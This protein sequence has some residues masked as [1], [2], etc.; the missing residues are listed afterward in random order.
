MNEFGD[1]FLTRWLNDELSA[2]ELSAFKKS[3]DYDM[4][5]KIIKG[6]EKLEGPH[7]NLEQTFNIIKKK[8]NQDFNSNIKNQNKRQ[9]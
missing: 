1:I 2:E 6:T 8:K 9:K 7:Y 5:V 3:T 4:Y